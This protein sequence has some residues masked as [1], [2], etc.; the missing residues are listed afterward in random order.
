MKQENYN[1]VGNILIPHTAMEQ[2]LGRINQCFKAHEGSTEPIGVAL[3]GE[4]RTGK[5][6]VLVHYESKHP[7]LRLDD[8]LRMPIEKSKQHKCIFGYI[9][10]T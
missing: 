2:A 3:I 1:L 6:R 5:S 7:K 4:S 8:G 9:F 10:D